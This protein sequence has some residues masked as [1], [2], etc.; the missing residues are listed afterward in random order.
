VTELR[1]SREIKFAVIADAQGRADGDHGYTLYYVTGDKDQYGEGRWILEDNAGVNCTNYNL[2]DVYR[3]QGEE[4]DA[5]GD[6]LEAEINAIIEADAGDISTYYAATGTQGGAGSEAEQ[7]MVEWGWLQPPI[8]VRYAAGESRQHPGKAI[9]YMLADVDGTELYAEAEPV[10]GD[11]TATYEDLAAEILSQAVAAGIDVTR[12]EWWNDET[13]LLTTAQA[14]DILGL[15]VQRIKQLCTEGRMGRKVG[16]DW[17]ISVED[18]ER[19]RERPGPGRPRKMVSCEVLWSKALGELTLYALGYAD[20]RYFFS[21]SEW[22]WPV[23]GAEGDEVPAKDVEDG[24]N[25][26]SWFDTLED[27]VKYAEDVFESL[28]DEEWAWEAVDE[29]TSGRDRRAMAE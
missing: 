25:G 13:P 3:N 11:E 24:E 4:L 16:R 27:A 9:D 2:T 1:A 22:R 21:W 5:E 6:R 8:L 19:N 28:D 12:L 29:L 17:V 7:L 14:A 26:I 20:G 18:L 15:S 23:Q 10:E